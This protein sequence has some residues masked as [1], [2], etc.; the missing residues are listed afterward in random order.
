MNRIAVRC[1]EKRKKNSDTNAPAE[2]AEEATQP[3]AAAKADM[4]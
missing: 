4:E 3:Q 1:A 2:I